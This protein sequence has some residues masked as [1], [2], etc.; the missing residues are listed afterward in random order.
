[1][2]P[3]VTADKHRRNGVSSTRA[4]SSCLP[5]MKTVS[6]RL[7]SWVTATSGTSP[8]ELRTPF[9]VSKMRTSIFSCS[10]M[11]TLTRPGR[12]TY[13]QLPRN[14]PTDNLR[15][16]TFNID[17]WLAHTPKSVLAKN[18]GVD[19]SVFEDLP[20]PNPYIVNGTV[21]E[22]N[23]TDAETPYA[24]GNSSFVYRLF[25]HEPEEIGGSGGSVSRTRTSPS[26]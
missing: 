11:E 23:V 6:T 22:R 9:R 14:D 3:F 12:L 21:S 4:K 26:L 19:E 7:R 17:D 20:A 10:T 8:R 2:A 24:T 25:D 1:M 15:S 18:F 5:L 13:C 16:T